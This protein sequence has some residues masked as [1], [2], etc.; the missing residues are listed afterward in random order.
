MADVVAGAPN[1]PIERPQRVP[2]HEIG[3][4]AGVLTAPIASFDVG[5]CNLAYCIGDATQLMWWRRVDVVDP[6]RKRAQTIA[7]SCDAISA[8]L[9]AEGDWSAMCSTVLI[10][11]QMRANVRAQRVSQHL[12]T[13]FRCKHP[14]LIVRFVGASRKTK[15]DD[16]CGA[17]KSSGVAII[18]PIA[19][20]ATEQQEMKNKKEKKS[21]TLTYAQRKRW[22][23]EHIESLLEARCR[24]ATDDVTRRHNANLLAYARAQPK[25]DDLCD[26]YAQ[27]LADCAATTRKR[28]AIRPRKRRAAAPSDN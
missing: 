23:V 6:T 20:A 15:S 14:S 13:W 5:E 25:R 8:V 18:S 24:A 9:A 16:K 21:S 19:P 10:E 27:L 28:A 3:F 4:A 12:W 7:E 2:A 17:V 26:A 22:T 11:M 1:A